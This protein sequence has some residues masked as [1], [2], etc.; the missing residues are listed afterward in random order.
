MSLFLSHSLHIVLA[1]F[2]ETQESQGAVTYLVDKFNQGGKVMWPILLLSL[3]GLVVI[4]E[5]FWFYLRARENAN[6]L[7]AGV[8]N[9]LLKER[10]VKKALGVCERSRSPLGSILKAGLLKFG[11]PRNEVAE[12]IEAASVQELSR[13]EKRLPVLAFIMTTAPMLGFLGTVVGMIASFATLA[14][15]G[16]K[17]PA[18]VANGISVA[19]ITTAGGLI[20]AIMVSPFYSY[21]QAKIKQTMKSIKFTYTFLL[22][23]LLLTCKENK[24]NNEHQSAIIR[25]FMRRRQRKYIPN[26]SQ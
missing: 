16:M 13:M 26:K 18:K 19:L 14:K 2:P 10:N 3:A 20:V 17:N 9:V 6:L 8:R 5:R 22:M 1:V 7:V 11:A 21:F 23:I 24:T 12:T 25:S 4:V 15:E